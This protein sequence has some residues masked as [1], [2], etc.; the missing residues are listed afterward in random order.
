MNFNISKLITVLLTMSTIA[1]IATACS[2]S[3]AEDVLVDLSIR[4]GRLDRDNDLIKVKQN[5]VITFRITADK[6]GSI[7]LHGYDFEVTVGPDEPTIME[8]T[9][10]STGRY[11]F[12]FHVSAIHEGGEETEMNEDHG[13]LFESPTL[14]PNQAFSFVILDHQAEYTIIFHNHMNHEMNGEIQVSNSAQETDSI[15]IEI[16]EDGSFEPHSI[17]VRPGTTIV[18]T[19]KGNK[20]ARPTSG[21]APMVRQHEDSNNREEKHE[22][23]IIL[24]T[25]EVHP[26]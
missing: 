7:H 15:Q 22:D 19:N 4:E 20:R 17:L 14:D 8:F 24:G 13:T 10:N 1:V 12:T 5:D 21:R 16:L 18:W 9:A 3:Q 11:P 26:R 2:S 25:L 6:H 23:E